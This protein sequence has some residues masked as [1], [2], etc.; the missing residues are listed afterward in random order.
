MLTM[1]I[2]MINEDDVLRSERRSEQAR[3][4]L[5]NPIYVDAWKKIEERVYEAFKECPT[6]DSAGLVQI[7]LTQSILL[8]LKR[9]FEEV[10]NQGKIDRMTFDANKEDKVV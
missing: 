5:E 9:D 7:R 1:V 3:N 4:I 8:N 2:Q 6:H 10:L